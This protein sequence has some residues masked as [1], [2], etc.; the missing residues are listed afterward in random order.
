MGGFVQYKQISLTAVENSVRQVYKW[1]VDNINLG[2]LWY[3]EFIYQYMNCLVFRTVGRNPLTQF[4]KLT[5]T[6]K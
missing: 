5:N 6:W 3:S 1:Y 4:C 2:N